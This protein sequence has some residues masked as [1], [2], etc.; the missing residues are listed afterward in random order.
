MLSTFSQMPDGSEI[1]DP[2]KWVEQLH[3]NMETL[4]FSAGLPET[5]LKRTDRFQSIKVQSRLQDIHAII[6]RISPWFDYSK[7]RSWLWFR[8][9]PIPAFDNKS[10]SEVLREFGSQGLIA[11]S[12]YISMKEAGGFE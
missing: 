11:I 2:R 10:A 12:D 7:E 9:T 5:S 6:E 8:S 4:A 1:E 3:T